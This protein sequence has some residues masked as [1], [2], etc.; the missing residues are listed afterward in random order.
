MALAGHNRGVTNHFGKI[1]T[2]DVGDTITL[3]TKLG[4]RN[5]SVTSV[6]KVDETDNSMLEATSENCITLFTCVRNQSAYRWCI[7][8]VE[9]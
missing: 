5:Y 1:H 3:T 4:T 9:S 2:L 8:G 6:M 7:R